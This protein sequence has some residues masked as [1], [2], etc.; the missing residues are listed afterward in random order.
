M[1]HE[2]LT[3]KLRELEDQFSHLSRRICSSQTAGH[4]QLQQD[5]A[6][7]SQE[8]NQAS[9]DLRQSLQQSRA[10][11]ASVLANAYAEVEQAIQRADNTLQGH[12]HTPG[13]SDAS[14]EEKILVAEYSLDFALLAA[15]RALLLSLQAIDAQ[16]TQEERRPL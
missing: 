5:M 16:L 3:L 14:S 12:A 4:E 8:W 15:N 2:I 10:Q 1:A 11:I 6:A 9:A 7:L 13:N